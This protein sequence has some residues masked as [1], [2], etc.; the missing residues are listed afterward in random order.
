MSKTKTSKYTGLEINEC[1]TTCISFLVQ[2]KYGSPECYG[3]EPKTAEYEGHMHCHTSSTG[4][5]RKDKTINIEG[6]IRGHKG[7]I[8]DALWHIEE[9]EKELKRLRNKEG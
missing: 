5:T 1:C 3:V 9:L 4:N 6:K 2:D 8:K 7:R